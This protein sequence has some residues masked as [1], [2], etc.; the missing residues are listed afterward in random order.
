MIRVEIVVKD[1]YGTPLRKS[2]ENRIKQ[3]ITGAV[4]NECVGQNFEIGRI[5]FLAA[6]PKRKR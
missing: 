6:A 1:Q 4:L 5:Q 2:A 3:V